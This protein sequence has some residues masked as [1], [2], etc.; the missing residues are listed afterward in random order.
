MSVSLTKI[1]TGMS[2]LFF[3]TDHEA[4]RLNGKYDHEYLRSEA[5][6]FLLSL[7][8]IAPDVCEGITS[9]DLVKDFYNRL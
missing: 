6:D 9:E 7:K 2:D 8:S 3:N 5:D 1:P 4:A